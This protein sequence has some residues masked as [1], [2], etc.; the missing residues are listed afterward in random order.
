[1]RV[2]ARSLG[3]VYPAARGP[4]RSTVEAYSHID[5][6]LYVEQNEHHLKGTQLE[7]ASCKVGPS[8]ARSFACLIRHA[9]R[10]RPAIAAT[11]QLTSVWDHFG[12]MP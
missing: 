3:D 7:D 9:P 6:F 8:A 2:S 5:G 1:M 4:G 11:L 12:A 10:N